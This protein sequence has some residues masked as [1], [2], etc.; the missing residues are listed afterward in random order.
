M[1]PTIHVEDLA[2]VT[3]NLVAAYPGPSTPYILAVDRS[4]LSMG[5]LLG[6]LSN[7]LGTG[8]MMELDEKDTV[9]IQEVEK[10]Q[11]DLNFQYFNFN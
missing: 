3:A 9:K 6:A 7:E 1:I 8:E 11:V 2:N 4:R 5:S 10:L